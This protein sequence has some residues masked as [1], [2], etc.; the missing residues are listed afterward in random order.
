MAELQL[1]LLIAGIVLLVVTVTDLLWTTLWVEGGA[2]PLTG[3]LLVGG[4]Q[5]L[6]WA[7]RF[8][9]RIRTLAGPL[10]L[11]G[12]LLA[13]V[14]LLWTG[15]TLIFASS[16]DAITDTLRSNPLSWTDWFYYAGYTIFTL[17]NGDFAPQEGP[18]QII[19]IIATGTGML[20]ITLSVSYILNVLS[21]VTQ[22]RAFASGVTGLGETGI[23]IVQTSWNGERLTGLDLP[24]NTFTSQLNT[25]T[26]NHKAYPILHYFHSKQPDQS[27]IVAI[28]ILH[29][30]LNFLQYGLASRSHPRATILKNARASIDSYL[31]TLKSAFIEPADHS[32][33]PP[34]LD[35]LRD[36]GLP[37]T[38]E[39]EFRTV[40]DEQEEQRQILLGLV[41]SDARDWPGLTTD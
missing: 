37:I 36:N 12:G 8:D 29:E 9:A 33:P 31:A 34:N 17:G 19:T 1:L 22:K 20:L 15:W 13:W 27:P 10:I 11:T 39:E 25:L 14:L 38:S 6:R 30:T 24:L 16:T 21:A 7:G 3:L 40:L 35:A 26:S 28:V 23:D 32:P 18:W 41:E 5:A 4:W 2:G